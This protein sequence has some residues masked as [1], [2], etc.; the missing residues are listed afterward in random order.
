MGF[1]D[2]KTIE[3][4]KKRINIVDYI[5]KEGVELR[6][7]GRTHSA[8]CPFHQETKAS[9]HVYEDTQSFNCFGCAV[10]GDIFKYVMKAEGMSYPESIASDN[11]CPTPGN[12][13]ATAEGIFPYCP[14]GCA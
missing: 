8:K 4:I 7:S 12:I 3:E 6:K 1:I 11:T 13:D 14:N 5:K 2:D 9:F 10:G